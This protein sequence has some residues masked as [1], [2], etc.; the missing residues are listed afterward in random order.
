MPLREGSVS[1]ALGNAFYRRR[2]ELSRDLGVLAAIVYRQQ[3]AQLQILDGMSACGV[4]ALR[5]LQEAEADFVWANDANP[6]IH[7]VLLANLRVVPPCRYRITHQSA[8]AVLHQALVQQQY[9]DL[10]D[11]DAFGNP[12]A[13]LSASLQTL[14]F[15]G[16]LYIT[17]TDG[18]S[19]S[20]QLPHQSMQQWG[21]YAR[22][23]PAV[24]EQALR[25]LLGSI[26]HQAMTLGYGIQPIFSLYS[27][28][29]FRV[30]VQL[31][32]K[33]LAIQA[34]QPIAHYGFLGYCH[35][36]GEFQTVDWR[37]LGRVRCN[38][39]IA[40][41]AEIAPVVSGPL[42]LGELHSA[43]WLQALRD[44]AIERRWS[45]QATL[46]DRLR[47]EVGM[48]PYFYTLGEVGRRGKMDIPQRTHL[49]R[50][51]MAAG[52]RFSRTHI[53]P[54][55]FKTD[56]TWATCL[57]LAQNLTPSSNGDTSSGLPPF[58]RLVY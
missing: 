13:F 37:S 9:F 42:W 16:L 2:S 18:R 30:M 28:S 43:D 33:P 48:P 56:A 39:A 10:I 27:G 7:S 53:D 35:Q 20:G 47:S 38:C 29:V 36:C 12:L 24:H 50:A 4:R 44:L 25:M 31:L 45:D 21:S 23:H 1:F 26:Y 34:K 15:G 55:G 49:Q 3:Q 5:Y 41:G 14:R 58:G 22:S 32:A 11:L 8:Q 19:L 54:E 52:Y 6:D 17:S 40:A 57:S 51:I 46:I